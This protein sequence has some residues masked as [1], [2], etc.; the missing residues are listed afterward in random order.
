MTVARAVDEEPNAAPELDPRIAAAAQ[1]DRRAAQGLLRDLL[2]RVRNLVRYLVNG[3]SDVDDMAQQALIA[4]LRG[5]PGF[6]GEGSFHGWVDRITVRETLAY[7]RRQRGERASR[8]EAAP[9]LRVVR[10]DDAPPDAYLERR[11]A[12]M[13]LDALPDD[14]R[15]VVVLHHV[16]GLSVPELSEELGIPFETARSRLRL[17]MQKLRSVHAKRAGGT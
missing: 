16:V 10:E 15:D 17:G 1:G 14:Q 6:R 3:D 8:W 13:L 11:E 7:A 9:D 2:P 12:A 5:L 4:V